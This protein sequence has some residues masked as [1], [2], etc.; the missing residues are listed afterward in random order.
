MNLEESK[1]EIRGISSQ[2]V[3]NEDIIERTREKKE[4]FIQKNQRRKEKSL[5]S[6]NAHDF[7]SVGVFLT[8]SPRDPK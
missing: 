2:N 7:Y 4:K 6:F 1:N 3:V 5:K 8:L